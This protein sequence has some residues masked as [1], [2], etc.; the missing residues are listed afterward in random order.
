[1][2]IVEAVVVFVAIEVALAVVLLLVFP[3]EALTLLAVWVLMACILYAVA[4]ASRVLD[5]FV[6]TPLL[7]LVKYELFLAAQLV[8]DEVWAIGGA[9]ATWAV[10]G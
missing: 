8:H 9:G 7:L 2:P 4:R 5:A 6:P 3:R 1:V 10:I